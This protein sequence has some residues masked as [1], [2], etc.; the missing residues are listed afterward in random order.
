[1]WAACLRWT[2][3]MLSTRCRCSAPV[4][5]ASVMN[6][7]QDR[8]ALPCWKDQH[9]GRPIRGNTSATGKDLKV[10]TPFRTLG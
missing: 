10:P 7:A 2:S 3:S 8:Q 6:L 9:G 5:V 1:M 4:K